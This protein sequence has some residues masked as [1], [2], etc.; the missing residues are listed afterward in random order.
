MRISIKNTLGENLQI[1][2]NKDKEGKYDL[3]TYI[4]P[5]RHYLLIGLE[6]DK[7]MNYL[8]QYGGIRDVTCPKALRKEFRN[9]IDW[10]YPFDI[11]KATFA[12]KDDLDDIEQIRKDINK[13]IVAM[14]CFFGNP[15]L[16]T[17]YYPYGV[18]VSVNLIENVDT[19]QYRDNVDNQEPENLENVSTPDYAYQT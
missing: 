17:R 1:T 12:T 15:K 7:I 13:F 18:E 5:V 19:E 2:P 16:E 8:T 14:R 10:K 11:T 6:Q 3:S 9:F 4:G